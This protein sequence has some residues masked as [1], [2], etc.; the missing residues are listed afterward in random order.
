MSKESFPQLDELEHKSVEEEDY[1]KKLKEQQLKLLTI[2]RK[3]SEKKQSLIIILEGPDAAGKGGAIKRIVER[4]DP[5]L[6][7]VYSVVKPTQEEYRH[8]YMW[9]F[10]NKLPPYG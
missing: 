2:Q 4:L 8:H 10:W 9:R 7:W 3:L 6:V 5:R 1:K